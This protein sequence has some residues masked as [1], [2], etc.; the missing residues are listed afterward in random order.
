MRKSLPA[1][2]A[3][4]L[5]LGAPVASAATAGGPVLEGALNWQH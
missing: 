2:L 3:I 4:G 1:L 5:M